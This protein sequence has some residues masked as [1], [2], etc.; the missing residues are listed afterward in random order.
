MHRF[1][2]TLL[3]DMR[4][5][6]GQI[7]PNSVQKI[8]VFIAQ[9]SELKLE[10]TLSLFW[11]LHKLQASRGYHPLFEIHWRG[12]K[13]LGGTL[14]VTPSSNKGGMRSSWKWGEV[15][16]PILQSRWGHRGRTPVG[17]SGGK[18]SGN[19]ARFA[20]NNPQGLWTMKDFNSPAFL[21][22]HDP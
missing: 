21:Y 1:F 5:G 16:S 19:G 9:C 3:V 6:I 20:G 14:V 11:C 2:H 8:C 4:L 22:T 13:K 12:G 18:W 10:P 17:T 15:P 7:G